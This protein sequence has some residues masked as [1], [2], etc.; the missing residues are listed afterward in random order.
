MSKFNNKSKVA[1]QVSRVSHRSGKSGKSGDSKKSNNAK[2]HFR[3]SNA[4]MSR[5]AKSAYS[6]GQ[7][8]LSQQRSSQLTS[9]MTIK[10]R[11]SNKSANNMSLYEWEATYMKAFASMIR[12][13]RIKERIH[14][15]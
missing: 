3:G 2:S 13:K 5:H 8:G 10:S 9:I 11:K 1:R 15:K 12:K 6:G 7:S 14:V 4:G